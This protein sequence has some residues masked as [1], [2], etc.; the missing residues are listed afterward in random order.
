[1]SSA[2]LCVMSLAAAVS[3]LERGGQRDAIVLKRESCSI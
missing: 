2:F 3:C 1:M